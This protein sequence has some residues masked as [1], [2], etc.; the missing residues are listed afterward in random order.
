MKYLLGIC[1]L[2]LLLASCKKEQEHFTSEPVSDYYPLQVGKYITYNLDSTIFTNFGQNQ[3]Q[4]HYQVKD[5]VDASI[6][7][8][9]GRPGFRIIRYSRKDASS[10]WSPNNVFMA[11]PTDRTLE[12]IEN[13]LRFIK[14]VLPIKQDYSWK[15]NSYIDVTSNDI[16]LGFYEDWD[17]IYDSVGVPLTINALNFDNTIKVAEIDY[18]ENNPSVPNTGYAER[19]YAVEKYAKGIGLIYREFLHWEYQGPESPTYGYTGYGVK[20]SIIDHN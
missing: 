9:L 18:T 10:D 4:V 16:S 11:V 15:G 6:T 2:V 12:F 19:T 5:V 14:L 17:Y 3:A 7:D 8:N 1:S 20:M 13:N